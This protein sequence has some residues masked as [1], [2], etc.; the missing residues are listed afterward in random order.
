MSTNNPKPTP[1]E[2][3]QFEAFARAAIGKP[4]VPKPLAKTE[5]EKSPS[6][7]PK[8]FGASHF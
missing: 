8:K 2:R 3:A 7:E 5:P 4:K 1:K 6:P